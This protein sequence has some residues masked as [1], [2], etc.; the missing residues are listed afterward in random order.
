MTNA[1][2]VKRSTGAT[3]RGGDGVDIDHVSQRTVPA[4]SVKHPADWRPASS[5]FA[6]AAAQAPKRKARAIVDV[7]TIAAIEIRKNVPKP[8]RGGRPENK[9]REILERMDVGD[10]VEMP[11]ADAIRFYAAA[12]KFASSCAPARAFSM[13]KLTPQASGIW[14]DPDREAA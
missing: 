4:S 10:M 13:R 7:T 12:K 1:H 6:A 8:D 14:R 2:H 9:Y 11:R 5:V 3:R